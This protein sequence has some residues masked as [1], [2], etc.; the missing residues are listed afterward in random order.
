MPANSLTVLVVDDEPD[1]RWAL[2]A[3]LQGEGYTVAAVACGTEA[4][5]WLKQPQAAC[6]LILVDAKLPDI[7]GLDL[8]SRIQTETAC[9]APMILVSGYFYKNS[10]S[11]REA[12]RAGLIR[13]FITKPYRHEEMLNV[14]HEVL[15]VE[16]ALL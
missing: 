10:G 6:H 12:L 14:V 8:A 2:Q 1:V 4:L 3:L 9:V 11:V 16:Q 5:E 15:S 7:E 13:A